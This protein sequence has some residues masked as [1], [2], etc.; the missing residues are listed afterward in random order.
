MSAT[1]SY[2]AIRVDDE[3][4]ADAWWCALDE[5][6]PRFANSLRRNGQ[7]VI[8][9]ALW[10]NLTVL[11]GYEDGP[12]F[13]PTALLCAGSGSDLWCDV[14]AGTYAVFETLD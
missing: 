11:P 13:A 14:N 6:Y 9:E 2:L 4:N 8:A 10:K 3:N 1:T 12:A 7:A 5:H